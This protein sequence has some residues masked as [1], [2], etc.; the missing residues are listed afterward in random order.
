MQKRKTR[1]VTS[2]LLFSLLLLC[3]TFIFAYS[4]APKLPPVP[5]DVPFIYGPNILPSP[6]GWVVIEA[7]TKYSG[8]LI[9]YEQDAEAVSVS[10]T[11]PTGGTIIGTQTAVEFDPND[12]DVI[13]P[14]KPDDHIKGKKYTFHWEWQT[15]IADVGL[16][17]IKV[18]AMDILG[19]KDERTFLALVKVNRPPIIG[20]CI[21]R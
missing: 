11:I 7:G 5:A 19:A 15:T 18:T 4:P 6:M 3:T 16:H 13:D 21:N 17:Y 20:G 9:V 10:I 12:P 1:V 14:N 8:D 2:C